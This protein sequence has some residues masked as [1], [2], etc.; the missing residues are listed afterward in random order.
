M[1]FAV[2]LLCALL[3]DPG[4]TVVCVDAFSTTDAPSA[5]P[6]SSSSLALYA[7]SRRTRASADEATRRVGSRRNTSSRRRTEASSTTTASPAR[8]RRA[9]R[10]AGRGVGGS[11]ILDRATQSRRDT[12]LNREGEH[13]SLDRFGG[14]VEF[15]STADLVTPLR[16]SGV[17]PSIDSVSE[18]LSDAKRVAGGLWDE[19]LLTDLGECTYRL[20]LMPL[21]FVTI[22]LAPTV[23]VKMWT[24]SDDSASASASASPVAVAP[25]FRLHSIGFDPNVQILPGIGLDASSLGITIEVCGELRPTPDGKGVTGKIGFQS[26]GE[27]PPPMRILPESVLKAAGATISSTV[28]EFAV[29]NFRSGAVKQYR[30]FKLEKHDSVSVD[31]QQE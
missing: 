2:A 24:D 22:Q 5:S 28:R 15:G 23:D 1:R 9:R 11:S 4:N 17:E 12:I 7:T 30:A 6:S 3:S 16:S 21:Q 18:W 26:S 20:G 27:L 8:G 29:A 31:A 25:T 19:S 13:F 10:V 14:K